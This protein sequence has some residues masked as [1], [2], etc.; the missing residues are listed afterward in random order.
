LRNA[1]IIKCVDVIKNTDGEVTELHCEFDPDTRSGMPGAARRVKGTIHWV[2]A[3]HAQAVE[4]RLYDRLFN[5]PNPLADKERDFLDFINPHS[6]DVIEQAWAEPSA[7]D[8]E[9]AVQFERTG[10]FIQDSE[11][12]SPDRP[13][14]NRTV[15]LRD[16]WKKMA[17]Q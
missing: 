7:L 2:S 13:V 12:S 14:F 9:G 15:T 1:F 5:E 6:L 10:Y 3:R 8:V 4:V 11:D 17:G 16:T